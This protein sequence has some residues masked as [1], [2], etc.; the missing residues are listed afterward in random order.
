MWVNWS[1]DL[2]DGKLEQVRK[3]IEN[4]SRMCW[5]AAFA[6]NDETITHGMAKANYL[7]GIDPSLKAGASYYWNKKDL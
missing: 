2:L 6:G 1:C 5:I 4:V 7:G 3:R